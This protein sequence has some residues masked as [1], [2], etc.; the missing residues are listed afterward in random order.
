MGSGPGFCISVPDTGSMASAASL[1]R[2][3]WL[4]AWVSVVMACCARYYLRLRVEGLEFR[5][6]VVMEYYVHY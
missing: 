2:M 5:V 1:R 6:S 4:L 3:S